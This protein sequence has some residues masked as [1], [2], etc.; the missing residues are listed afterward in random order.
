MA[1][2]RTQSGGAAELAMAAR[3]AT[4]KRLAGESW[5][6]RKMSKTSYGSNRIA[7]RAG[8]GCPSQLPGMGTSV[9]RTR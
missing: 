5:L 6:T 7:A 1:S 2:S 3:M 9:W 4:Q 8:T